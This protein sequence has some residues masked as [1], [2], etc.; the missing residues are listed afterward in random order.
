MCL[1]IKDSYSPDG[2]RGGFICFA[3]A[4]FEVFEILFLCNHLLHP[5]TFHSV[6]PLSLPIP[7]PPQDSQGRSRQ[8]TGLGLSKDLQG[9]K[10][11]NQHLIKKR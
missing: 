8:K 3:L 4:F 1:I 2:F 11:R 5:S 7:T 10:A 9:T 6:L